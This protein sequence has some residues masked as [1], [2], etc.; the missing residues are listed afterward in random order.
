M[1]EF[2]DMCLDL[3]QF[4]CKTENK[5]I[6]SMFLLTEIQLVDRFLSGIKGQMKLMKATGRIFW[7]TD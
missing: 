4:F 5:F 2:D 7:C 3:L 6:I 1:N